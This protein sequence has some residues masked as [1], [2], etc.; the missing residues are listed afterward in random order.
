VTSGLPRELRTLEVSPLLRELILHV[1]KM[2]SLDRRIPTQARLIAVLLDQMST[3]SAV[4]LQ[5]PWPRDPRARWLA[6][7]LETSPGDVRS[8]HALAPLAGAGVR[9]L[10]RAFV[11]ETKMTLGE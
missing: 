4:P 8:T 3:V 7:F 1:T 5:L 10:E 11:A 9:T 6:Q 2:G